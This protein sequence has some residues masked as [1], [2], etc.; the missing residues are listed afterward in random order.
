[1]KQILIT[2]IV[3]LITIQAKAQILQPVHW[4]YAAKKTGKTAA[5]VFIK[6]SMDAGWHIYSQYIKDG[7]PVK[8]TILFNPSETFVLSG[9]T[10]EP[11]P[12]RKME[13]AFGMEVA[14]FEKEVIFQQKIRLKT[15]QVT[16][17]GKLEF[18]TCNDEKCLPP[19][20]LEFSIP[21][22]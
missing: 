13:K 20:N 10:A 7:G 2:A 14:Y 12:I 16:V 15:G 19:D 6:A 4:S 9:K 5:V 1:M 17:N 11:N 21:V 18:M 8:T 3:L 22:K